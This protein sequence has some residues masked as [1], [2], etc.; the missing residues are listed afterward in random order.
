VEPLVASPPPPSVWVE[1]VGLPGAGKSEVSRAVAT[2]LRGRGVAVFEPSY[3]LDHATAPAERRVSK[4][5]LAARGWAHSRRQSRFWLHT[6]VQSRQQSARRLRAVTLNWFYL[7][8][9]A[10]RCGGVPG[11]HVFD[12]GLLQGLWSIGYAAE[13]PDV[14]SLSLLA[15]LRRA[16][17]PR[18][19]VVLVDADIPT[20]RQRLAGRPA[21][22]SRLEHDLATDHSAAWLAKATRVLERVE[23]IA[24][25]LTR[26]HDLMMLRIDGDARD[27]V[28]TH[29]A[30]IV[31]AISELLAGPRWPNVS[32]W[33]HA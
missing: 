25:E 9:S 19:L 4:L 2:L 28:P 22:R 20:I 16:L 8:G 30:A 26:V 29:A 23:E 3:Q 31:D 24:C 21:G 7:L 18:G 15:R 14:I 11:I 32:R 6:L 12:Q 33:A 27:S 13:R 5:W 1:F 10:Q 17:P